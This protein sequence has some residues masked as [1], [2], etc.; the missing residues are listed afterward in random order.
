MVVAVPVFF[1]AMPW[2]IRVVFG[3]EYDG[4]VHAARSDPDRRRD[5]L[6]ARLDEVA[7]VTIGRPRLRI[8]THGLE[9]IVAIP[10]VARARSRVGRDRSGGR[11]PRRRRSCSPLAWLVVIVRLRDEVHAVRESGRGRVPAVRV[12]VVSGI[13]PPDPGGP[14]EPR[15][16]ARRLPHRARARRRGRDDGRRRAGGVGRIP[17]AG[18]RGGRRCGMLRAALLV[19]AAARR[20]DV[21]YATSM[22]RR[23][24]IGC[25]ARAAAARREARVRRGLRA[26]DA[27]RPLR[28][29]AGRV[30]AAV[31]GARTRFLRT[32]RNAALKRA[33]HVFCPSRVPA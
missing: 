4:A 3:S 7:P 18:R 29:H 17:C 6:R 33:R 28:R 24:A 26:R 9:T 12:V 20:A 16:R 21:V 23:A 8:V 30:P 31:A 27:E 15:S 2:L 32:S 1:V 5:P 10:L 14:G 22:I 25:A 11:R 13:W 19:R